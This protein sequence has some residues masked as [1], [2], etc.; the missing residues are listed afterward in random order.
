MFKQRLFKLF[1]AL[2]SPTYACFITGQVIS[3]LGQWMKRLALSW[4]VF[5]LTES[6]FLLAVVEFLSLSPILFLGLFA[7]AWLERHDLRKALVTTQILCM[8]VGAL[9]TVFTFAGRITYPLLA[10]LSLLLGIVGAFDMTARQSAV[11]LMVDDHT[12]VK[13][14]VAL[15]S[16]AFN[17]S[18]LAGP[19]LAGFMVWLWGEGICFL[20]STLA[21]LPIIGMLIFRIRLRE[22]TSSPKG[23]SLLKDMAEGLAYVRDTFY[24]NRMFRL[25]LMF[26]LLAPCYV[27]LFPT[28]STQILNGGAR[29]LG[30]LL[31]AV[32]AGAFLGGVTVSALSTV[33]GIPVS[34]LRSTALTA[35]ALLIFAFS[36]Q[37]WLSLAAA[38]FIGLG[39]S[40]TGISVNTLCQTTT[41]D[42]MRS[43]VISLYVMCVAGS[44]P[45][46]GL[47]GGA[48]ADHIDAPPAMIVCTAVLLISVVLYLRDLPRIRSSLLQRLNRLCVG[49]DAYGCPEPPAP[50]STQRD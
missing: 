10:A 26:C 15:N 16:M 13:S 12:A 38:F 33:R 29:T 30:W 4:M 36:E 9:L 37:L 32:G 19:S 35:A 31:G 34:L 22:R 21:Y 39:I 1:P 8:G 40:I 27:V 49:A 25:F 44:A 3:M 23:Q 7:G 11:S 20:L 41:A 28:F 43:R 42:D 18:K 6:A 24:L 5:R 17:I 45:I 46:G 47:V 14:A 2:A 50:P 48:L